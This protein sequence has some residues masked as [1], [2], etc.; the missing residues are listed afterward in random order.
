MLQG[1]E[2]SQGRERSVPN[3]ARTLDLDIVAMGKGGGLRRDRPDPILPH[4]RAQDRR[5]VLLPLQDVAPRW[6]HPSLGLD[7]D[8]L[9]A[10]LP[11]ADGLD[12]DVTVIPPGD[13]RPGSF[14][15]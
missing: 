4:P 8:G 1:I 5:F 3:A 6:V 10:A 12:G 15:W 2:L 14:R 9:L 11:R 7:V 13:D